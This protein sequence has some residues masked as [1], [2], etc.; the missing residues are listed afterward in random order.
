VTEGWPVAL[1]GVTE[2]VVTTEGPN[3][4]FNVAALGIHA[5]DSDPDSTDREDDV[6]ATAR[7]WGRTRTRRN[8]TER[9]EGYVQFVRDP[10]VFVDATL[11][12]REVDEP[13]LDGAHAWVRVRV[14]RTDGGT[15]GGTE[16]VDWRLHPV[17][18]AVNERV[19][20]AFNRG[21]AA[22]VE[23]TVAASR[24]DVAAY[25]TDRLTERIDY[26]ETV[27]HR[28]GGAAE[29][30]AFERIREFVEDTLD[31]APAG[32]DGR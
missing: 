17:E 12:V 7:T 29:R 18:Q 4:R 27:A 21:Y 9:G 3:G 10:L 26:F 25:D 2:S 32:T 20:P 6:V 31:D 23:A 5:P 15:R 11:G 14:E 24:L 30:D 22:V 13:V 16:W 8:F 1:R 19:V 28:C